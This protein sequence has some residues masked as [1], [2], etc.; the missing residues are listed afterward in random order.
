MLRRRSAILG[1]TGLFGVAFALSLLTHSTG[2]VR[3]DAQVFFHYRWA[4]SEPHVFARK[5]HVFTDLLRYSDGKWRR[6]VR[7]PTRFAIE[8]EFDWDIRRQWWLT[9][10][11][12]A[13]LIVSFGFS[14]SQL[15][16]LRRG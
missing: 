12:G 5:P 2:V 6:Q 15:S 9:L 14:V 1:V 10:V 4:A 13:L 11:I 16:R 3:N 7:M 8:L